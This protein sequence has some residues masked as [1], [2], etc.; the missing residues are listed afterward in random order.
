MMSSSDLLKD[1]LD[2]S[3]TGDGETGCNNYNL[4]QDN[5]TANLPTPSDSGAR[6]DLA[7]SSNDAL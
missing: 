1:Q 2:Q 5:D 4:S 6:M 7:K 3:A